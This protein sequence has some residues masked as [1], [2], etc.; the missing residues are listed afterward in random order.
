M[1]SPTVTV[2]L[3]CWSASGLVISMMRLS[4]VAAAATGTSISVSQSPGFSPAALVDDL[5]VDDDLV[6]QTSEAG[7]GTLP[8]V[9]G[10]SSS[11]WTSSVL[12]TTTAV[13]GR[14]V[15]GFSTK[16]SSASQVEV[17]YAEAGSGSG[18]GAGSVGGTCC[19]HLPPSFTLPVRFWNSWKPLSHWAWT[20]SVAC[21]AL[22]L[23]G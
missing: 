13:T 6:G 14:P 9:P 21:R 3:S 23:P 22:V 7:K 18:S 17:E 4:Q 15:S 5:V 19:L 16:T 10:S 12:V 20:V 11:C 8:L 1:V 2:A